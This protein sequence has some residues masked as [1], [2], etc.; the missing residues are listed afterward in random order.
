M[1]D[2]LL[3]TCP[4]LSKFLGNAFL[5]WA[6][7]AAQLLRLGQMDLAFL[8]PLSHL[9]LCSFQFTKDHFSH[10]DLDLAFFLPKPQGSPLSPAMKDVEISE[11]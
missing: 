9:H 2:C 7:S 5:G 10:G 8:P 3:A 1:T 11:T 4:K 6:K